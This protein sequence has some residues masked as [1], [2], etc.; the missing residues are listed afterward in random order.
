MSSSPESLLV[1]FASLTS[2]YTRTTQVLSSPVPPHLALVQLD[3]SSLEVTF[4]DVYP[5]DCGLSATRLHRDL[6]LAGA[7]DIL[8]VTCFEWGQYPR[9]LLPVAEFLASH[10]D[11]RLV[12]TL[13]DAASHKPSIAAVLCPGEPNLVSEALKWSGTLAYNP[14]SKQYAPVHASRMLTVGPRL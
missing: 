6:S 8:I 2:P 3:R 4:E 11:T 12:E 1:P 10:G 13:N 14:V 7:D 9:Q 5:L